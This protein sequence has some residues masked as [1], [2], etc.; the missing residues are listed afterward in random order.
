MFLLGVWVGFWAALWW[1]AWVTAQYNRPLPPPR[2]ANGVR[3]KVVGP[4]GP[5]PYYE[6]N[7]GEP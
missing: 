7:H 4:I 6:R 5:M 3:V 1:D 2:N